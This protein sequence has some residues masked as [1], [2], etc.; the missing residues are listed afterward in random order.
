MEGIFGTPHTC[1]GTLMPTSTYQIYA[2]KIKSIFLL[3]E[4]LLSEQTSSMQY[5]ITINYLGFGCAEDEIPG[6]LHIHARQ[7]LYH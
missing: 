7:I 4:D 3:K 2:I 5:S 1:S 6:A